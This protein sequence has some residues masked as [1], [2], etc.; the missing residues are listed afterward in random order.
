MT[1]EI[2]TITENNMNYTC[3]LEHRLKTCTASCEKDDRLLCCRVKVNK[4]IQRLFN[5]TP[6][7]PSA[8]IIRRKFNVT[9]QKRCECF[10]CK[11]L[12]PAPPTEKSSTENMEEGDSNKNSVELEYSM[13]EL[14]GGD[15]MDK[16]N[17]VELND[18]ATTALPNVTPME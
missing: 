10:F 15:D 14:E 16:D 3:E 7:D 4:I 17:S 11:D 12:C 18:E 5:C 8:S 1:K 2:R 6:N 9:S 13:E